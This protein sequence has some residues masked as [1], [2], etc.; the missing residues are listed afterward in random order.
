MTYT[1]SATFNFLENKASPYM[2]EARKAFTNLADAETEI[3]SLP[4]ALK[5]TL[6]SSDDGG[7]H[8]VTVHSFLYGRYRAK[9]K[10]RLEL[11]LNTKDTLFETSESWNRYKTLDELL[12]NLK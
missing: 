2:F 5:P 4:P 10:A 8:S 6:Y 7:Y 3:M 1:I 11:L 9:G 12:E